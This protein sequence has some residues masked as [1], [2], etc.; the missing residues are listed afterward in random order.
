[1]AAYSYIAALLSS[2]DLFYV[3]IQTVI[4][5]AIWNIYMSMYLSFV[6]DMHVI[7]KEAPKSAAPVNPKLLLAPTVMSP[8]PSGSA[9]RIFVS[10]SGVKKGRK[11]KIV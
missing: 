10:E 3:V 2:R 4:D 9:L 11:E 8:L 6:V 5:I 7:S 1:M